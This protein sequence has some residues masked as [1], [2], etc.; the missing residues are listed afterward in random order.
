MS[1]ARHAGRALPS[2]A[3][4]LVVV[5]I[6]I[7]GPAVLSPTLVDIGILTA[8]YLVAGVGL[9]VLMGYTG[10]VSFGQ[11][12]FWAIGAYSVGILTAKADLPILGAIVLSVVIT[13]AV[14][15]VIGWPVTQLRGHYLAVATL[16]FALIVV[17][18]ANNL[19]P[20]TGGNA[21]LTGVPSL[22]VL[23]SP[24]VGENLYRLCWVLALIVLVLTN[25]ISRSRA[26]RAL[27]AVGA[28]E[29]G[30]SALGVPASAYRL[31]AFVL[32]AVLAG[33]AGALYAP[34]LGFLSPDAFD[35]SLSALL[36][37]V[38]VVGGM[39]SVYGALV[40]A[41]A[42]TAL[43]QWLVRTAQNPDLPAVLAPALNALTYGLVIFLVMRLYPAGLLPLLENTVRAAIA[44]ARRR[45]RRAH[46]A[47]PIIVSHADPVR[48]VASQPEASTHSVSA[49]VPEK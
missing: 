47:A 6:A 10:Q 23:G 13:A 43:S 28:D 11:G 49:T 15:F 7:V 42:I 3:W 38:V 9:N 24:I 34:Y 2:L 40:G 46:T 19:T 20:L 33:L 44:S 4:P 29:S 37:I 1:P 45:G 22:T 18:L 31:K 35:V 14:A 21:G 27:R 5:L 48:S 17:D 32:A 25:N 8:L 36:L 39:R 41:V 12:G 26:G 30:S 16:A